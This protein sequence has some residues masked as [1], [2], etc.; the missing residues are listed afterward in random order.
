MLTGRPPIL[1]IDVYRSAKLLVSHHGQDAILKAA[2][3]ADELLDQCDLDGKR[4]WLRIR[5]VVLELLKVRPEGEA[6][7]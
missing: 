1:D 3:R 4:V 2:L 5:A 6:V 7:H